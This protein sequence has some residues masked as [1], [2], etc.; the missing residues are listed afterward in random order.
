M[1]NMITQ[2][3]PLRR[4]LIAIPVLAGSLQYVQKAHASMCV[5]KATELAAFSLQTVTKTVSGK[6]VNSETGEGMPGVTVVVKRSALVTITDIDGN[7]QLETDAEDSLVF[8]FV[9]EVLNFP[10]R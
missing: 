2:S 1:K 7:Y 6:V 4:L 10:S 8:S 5:E 3:K 9:V